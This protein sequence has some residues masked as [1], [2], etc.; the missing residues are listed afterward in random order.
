MSKAKSYRRHAKKRL[1]ERYG[2]K[3]NRNI[4]RQIVGKI[5]KNKV[6]VI[7]KSSNSRTLFYVWI[8]NVKIKVVYD[9]KRKEI[10]TALPIK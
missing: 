10:V 5:Q 8:D 4:L 7:G 9:K 3:V 1:L 6:E 2:L